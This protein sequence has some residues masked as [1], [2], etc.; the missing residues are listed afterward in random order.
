MKS[1]RTS[2]LTILTCVFFLTACTTTKNNVY[3]LT[4]NYQPDH[5]QLY[6]TIVH[7]DS[8]FF[9]AYNTCETNLDTYASF[10]SEDIEFY[11]DQGGLMTSKK[12]IVDATKRNICGK[13]TRELVK[14]SIEVYPIKDFGAV[15]IGLHTFH[16]NQEPAPKHS[17]VGRFTIVWKLENDQWKITKVIS[18]H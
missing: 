10:Y 1:L 12:D 7:L 2:T 15:E 5:Q 11:H 3:Q 13:V 17:K 14:G 18:L 16:N 4:K 9:G 6:D 8:A